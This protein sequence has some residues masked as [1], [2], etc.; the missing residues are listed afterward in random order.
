MNTTAS[1]IFLTMP[2]RRTDS[3]GST[4][5]SS[6]RRPST[7]KQRRTTRQRVDETVCWIREQHQWSIAELIRFYIVSDAEEKGAE[8]C[9]SRVAKVVNAIFENEQARQL[10]IKTATE[11]HPAQLLTKYTGILRSEQHALHQ[12]V[13]EFGSLEPEAELGREL[14]IQ[15][16]CTLINQHAPTL[17]SLF[18]T[19]TRN[20]WTPTTE[21]DTTNHGPRVF[22]ILGIMNFCFARQNGSLLQ[23]ELGLYIKGQIGKRRMI[24]VLSTLG[25]TESWTSLDRIQQRVVS[26]AKARTN[27]RTFNMSV[28]SNESTETFD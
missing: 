10:F 6:S 14:D 12:N 25:I 5:K 3:V 15:R 16:A 20:R 11:K 23:K 22:M 13:P 26:E 1:V 27:R 24:N 8:G 17:S 18:S 9:E 4:P 28:R 2:K 19:L 7:Y 21:A